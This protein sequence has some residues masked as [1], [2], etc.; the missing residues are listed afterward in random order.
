MNGSDAMFEE[1]K[2]ITIEDL[3]DKF[4]EYKSK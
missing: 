2:N 1:Q 3:I 4:R